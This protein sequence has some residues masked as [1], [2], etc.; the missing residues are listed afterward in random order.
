MVARS[1]A[2]EITHNAPVAIGLVRDGDSLG[3]CR[4]VFEHAGELDGHVLA[5]RCARQGCR[6]G[7]GLQGPLLELAERS[8]RATS[9]RGPLLP[10]DLPSKEAG[11]LVPAGAVV[12][13]VDQ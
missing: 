11:G 7:C 4:L 3:R 13:R 12:L 2:D 9:C 10:T 6:G 5:V 8:P 1:S